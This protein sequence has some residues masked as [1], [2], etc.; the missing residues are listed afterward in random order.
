MILYAATLVFLFDI[1]PSSH[2][3]QTGYF[4]D[5]FQLNRF[6]ERSNSDI[7]AS[8]PNPYILQRLLGI[9]WDFQ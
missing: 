6:D 1:F 3:K 2:S 5:L 4:P 9:P 8:E 7:R